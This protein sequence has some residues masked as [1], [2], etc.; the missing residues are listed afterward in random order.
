MNPDQNLAFFN[1][2]L[3]QEL[4]KLVVANAQQ[5]LSA[6]RILLLTTLPRHPDTRPE[7]PAVGY[8]GKAD[9]IF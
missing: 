5:L 3:S 7:A 2:C 1:L 8:D 4:E 9:D 6:M